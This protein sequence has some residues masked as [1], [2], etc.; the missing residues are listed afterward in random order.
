MIFRCRWCERGYCEDCLDWDK[1]ELLG[2]NLKE[3]ELL[4]FPAVN[5]AFYICC[6]SCTDYHKE[7][8]EAGDFCRNM[9]SQV[10]EKY[11]KMLEGKAFIAVAGEESAKAALPP[12]RSESLTDAT[13]LDCSRISTPQLHVA[14]LFTASRKSLRKAVPQ[15]FKMSQSKRSTKLAV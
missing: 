7:N 6:P 4:G 9:A 13:T 14:E 3:Y 11:K 10:D 12:S 1:T 2:E 8:Q 15:S 5:Q